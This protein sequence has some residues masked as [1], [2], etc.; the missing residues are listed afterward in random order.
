MDDENMMDFGDIIGESSMTTVI[1]NPWKNWSDAEKH[2]M[3]EA[4]EQ[5]AKEIEFINSCWHHGPESQQ[6]FATIFK[7]QVTKN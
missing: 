4:I 3:Q 1:A 2:F 7:T 6:R 5:R